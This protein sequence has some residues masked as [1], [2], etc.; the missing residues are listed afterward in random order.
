MNDVGDKTVHGDGGRKSKVPVN[1]ICGPLGIGKTTSIIRYLKG[2]AGREFVAV[3]VNDFGPVGLDAAIIEGD[4]PAD[5][6]GNTSIKILPGGC[7]CCTSAVNLMGALEDLSKLPRVDRIIVEPSGLAMVGDMVDVLASVADRFSLELRPVIALVEP[8]LLDRVGFMKAPYYVRMVEAADVLVANRC[9]MA[10]ENH[11]ERF[12]EWAR[13]LYPPKVRV[14]MTSHGEIPDEVFEL[15]REPSKANAGGNGAAGHLAD[16]Y[17]GGC[18]FPADAVFET[19]RVEET[20]QQMALKGV[21]GNEVLRLKAIL[22]TTD[23]WNLYEI[24]RGQNYSRPTD[25]RRDSRVDWITEGIPLLDE[26][27]KGLFEKC[28]C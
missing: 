24:A 27:V 12:K 20:L 9:D 15:K 5:G 10:S 8:R 28:R 6:K 21:V 4:L 3:L 11:I 17:S 25:Y 26:F 19:D 13:G 7:V 18:I 2:H 14:V 22:N 16:Q 1:L 23:G